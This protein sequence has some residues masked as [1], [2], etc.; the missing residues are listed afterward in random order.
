[1]P[2]LRTVV[3]AVVCAVSLAACGGGGSD[4]PALGANVPYTPGQATTVPQHP[5]VPVTIATFRNVEYPEVAATPKATML[6][7]SLLADAQSLVGKGVACAVS[8]L[9]NDTAILSFRW[10]CAGQGGL[11]ATY[12]TASG[13]RLALGDLFKAGY[14]KVLSA[15]AVTQLRA[16]GASSGAAAKAAPPTAAAFGDWA[17]DAQALEVTFDPRSG[18]RPAQPVII[19]FPL[20]SLSSIIDPAGPLG[21]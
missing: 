3:A 12:A 10:T 7:A 15:T 19:S 9:R 20:A 6:N 5:P 16:G 21:N 2:H 14:L 13:T 8:T 11:T 4:N 17:I 1:M 18:S